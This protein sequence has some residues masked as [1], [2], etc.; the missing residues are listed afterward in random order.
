MQ[1]L[2]RRADS[3]FGR[4][5][6][7][8]SENRERAGG[9]TMRGKTITIC[10]C[11]APIVLPLIPESVAGKR[12]E[13]FG[14]KKMNYGCNPWLSTISLPPKFSYPRLFVVRSNETTI[15][16]SQRLDQPPARS[17]CLSCGRWRTPPSFSRSRSARKLNQPPRGG[18]FSSVRRCLR[19]LRRRQA[20]VSDGRS[21]HATCDNCRSG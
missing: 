14:G 18:D 17:D 16:T 11:F 5:F 2:R 10:N 4:R 1:P 9:K 12:Q 13:D 3:E 19:P 8:W 15:S 7:R 21:R 6:V 20:K